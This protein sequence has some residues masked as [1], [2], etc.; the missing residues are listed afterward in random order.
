VRVLVRIADKPTSPSTLQ[1][2]W[3][4]F[5]PRRA[6]RKIQD[7]DMTSKATANGSEMKST[8]EDAGTELVWNPVHEKSRSSSMSMTDEDEEKLL[9][10]Y[11]FR[12]WA[13]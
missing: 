4:T 9:H 13:D 2:L 8:A 6:P 3:A 7:R 5:Q 1:F 10:E 11:D 12:P